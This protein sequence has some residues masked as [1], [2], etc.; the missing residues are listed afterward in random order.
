MEDLSRLSLALFSRA[1]A[2]L[3]GFT[4]GALILAAMPATGLA[5]DTDYGWTDC[6]WNDVEATGGNLT[7]SYDLYHPMPANGMGDGVLNSFTNRVTDAVS[8]LN[9]ALALAPTNVHLVN[10]TSQAAKVLVHNQ[11]NPLNAN[12]Y[13]GA[14]IFTGVR[15]VTCTPPSTTRSRTQTF[16]PR[17]GRTGSPKTTRALRIGSRNAEPGLGPPIRAASGTTLVRRSR[18]SSGTQP[19]YSRIPST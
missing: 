13:F 15:D 19:G 18:T 11:T 8:R 2:A 3:V 7:W 5:A 6:N 4:I 17:S 14:T 1:R 16:T 12:E 9:G 10:V